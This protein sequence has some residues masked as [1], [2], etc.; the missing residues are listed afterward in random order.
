MKNKRSNKDILRIV[1]IIF[2]GFFLFSFILCMGIIG[3][4]ADNQETKKT[5]ENYK[6]ENDTKNKIIKEKAKITVKETPTI[7][8]TKKPTVKPTKKIDM[9][10]LQLNILK[11]NFDGVADIKYK[12]E[13]KLI[14]IIPIDSS[15]MYEANQA[16]NQIRM[17]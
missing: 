6:I 11:K 14:E 1:L 2:G 8:P 5:S 16:Y 15:F 4:F 17:L 7:K 9:L 12:K 10:N 3:S 13:A